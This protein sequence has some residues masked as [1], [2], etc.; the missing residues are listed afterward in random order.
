M[1]MYW[2]V[3]AGNLMRQTID[4]ILEGKFEYDKGSLDFSCSRIELT[5]SADEL[6][7]GSFEILCDAGAASLGY[8]Y[9]SD[10]RMHLLTDTF[11]GIGEEIGYTFSAKGLEEGDVVKGEI[12]VISNHGEYYL[13]YVVTIAHSTLDSSLGNIRNLFHFANLAKTNWD[14]AVKLFYSERF[15]ELFKGNDKQFLCAYKGLSTYYG[16]EQNVE[17][18]LLEINKK[19]P[20]EYIV[21]RDNISLEEPDTSVMEYIDITRNGWGYTCL[22]V[23]C[24]ADFVELS[25]ENLTDNDFLGNYLHYPIVINPSKL[26]SGNNYATIRFFNAFTS[27]EVKVRVVGNLMVKSAISKNVEFNRIMIDMVT[28]YQAFRLRRIN[29]DTWLAETGLIVDRLQALRPDDRTAKMFKAQLLITEERYNEAKWILDQIENSFEFSRECASPEWAYFLYL[30]TLI[31]REERYI[32]QITDEVE[33]IYNRDTSQWRVAWLLLYLSAEYAVSPTK[34]WLFITRQLSLN[35][36]SPIMYVEAANM[37]SMNAAMLTKLEPVEVRILRYMIRENLLTQEIARQAVYLAGSGK[38][39]SDGIIKILQ[40]CYDCLQDSESLATLCNLLI[41]NDK[42]GP[43]FFQWF[44]LAIEEEARVTKIYEYYMMSLDISRPFDLPKMVFMYFSY[45]NE[46][47]WVHTA[48]LYARVIER[49]EELEDLFI[50]YK[51]QIDKFTINQI[52]EGHMNRDLAVIYRFVLNENVISKDMAIK[53]AKLIFTHRISIDSDVPTKV[54]VY[55]SREN[56]G[57]AYPIV[58]REAFVPIYNKDFSIMFED[59]FSNRYMKSINYDIEKLMVPGKLANMLLPY[60]DDN[61]SFDVYACECSSEMVEIT[62]VNRVRYQR[63]LDSRDID[64]GY[65]TEIR[66]KL[67][68]YYYDNDQI[69]E[70]DNVLGSLEPEGMNTKERNSCIRFMIIRGMYDKAISWIY[71]FGTEGVDPRDLVKLCSNLIVRSDFEPSG[72]ITDISSYCFAKN[73][74]DETILKYLCDNYMGMTKDLRKLF[75]VAEN[76]DIDVF[77]MCEKLLVQMLFTGYFVSER[78]DIYRKYIQGGPSINIQK[79]FLAQCCFDY[80]VKEQL[81]ESYVFEEITRLKSQNEKLMTVVKLAYVKFYSENK[82]LVEETT[83]EYIKEFLDDLISEGIYF[84]Y[85]KE[86][87][88][89]GVEEINRFADKT[90]IEYKTEPGRKVMIH[91]IV[92]CGEDYSGEY[93]TKEMP[94]MYGGLHSMPFVLFFGENLLY[95]IT[96]EIDGEEQLTESGNITK[97]D[98]G[99]DISTSRFSEI[100]DIVISHTLQDYEA[101]EHLVYEYR[102]KEYVINKMFTMK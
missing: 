53:L 20:T 82:K 23:I 38:W 92:E 10:I 59:N 42:Y 15:A 101:L 1:Q 5:L 8:L 70:L 87:M 74:Y 16:N 9:S 93:I 12:Y 31:N 3:L 69:L 58:N 61:L 30:T 67:M 37:L 25:S 80:F 48:Y 7:T 41:A 57:E 22:S 68:Q 64:E 40:A 51:D 35:C 99:S 85:F 32:D 4:R 33:N 78:M 18:F 86:F 97:S 72:E 91:Y 89:Q 75:T 76:F 43:E 88:E 94:D 79:A 24:D 81:T 45:Q 13:P 66:T 52:A 65:K 102:R 73:K 46:L 27:F 62:D 54:I 14:E 17:E 77:G 50:A 47:D 28:Y 2:Q 63:I 19:Q 71:D 29:T 11:S 100:N 55:Q 21:D 26:H 44:K 90:F 84:S 56:V 83:G 96:E 34:K 60:V 98:I 95:Y 39:Y 36:T 49:R 6:Y